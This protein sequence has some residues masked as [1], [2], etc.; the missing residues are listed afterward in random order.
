MHYG[1][2]SAAERYQLLQKIR[3]L[4]R[5]IAEDQ[6]EKTK[7]NFDKKVAYCRIRKRCLYVNTTTLNIAVKL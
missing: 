7:D 1:E 5:N 4:A 2:S 3:F 6:G